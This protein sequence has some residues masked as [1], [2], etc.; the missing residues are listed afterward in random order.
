M[1]VYVLF[2]HMMTFEMIIGILTLITFF[3]K[4]AN[5][6]YTLNFNPMIFQEQGQADYNFQQMVR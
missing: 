4:I 6:T 1:N 2:K 3:F 5:T